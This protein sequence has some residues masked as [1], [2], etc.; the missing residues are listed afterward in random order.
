MPQQRWDPFAL[1]LALAS[2]SS[3][4]SILDLRSDTLLHSGEFVISLTLLP[5]MMTLVIFGHLVLKLDAVVGTFSL[6]RF[7]FGWR[8]RES[9]HFLSC[10]YRIG[11]RLGY[12]LLAILSTLSLLQNNRIIY[13]SNAPVRHWFK[14]ALHAKEAKRQRTF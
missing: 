4:T 6:I 5:C 9:D 7:L 14:T 11:C 12:L 10:D 8:G 13:R 1:L 2:A 3:V